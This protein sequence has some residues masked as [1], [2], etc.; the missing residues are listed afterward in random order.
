MS[1]LSFPTSP[2]TGTRYLNPNGYNTYVFDGYSW[3]ATGVDI[4]PNPNNNLFLYRTIYTRG[5]THCGYQ[6]SSPWRNTNRTMHNTDTTTNLGDMMDNS[7]AYIDVG[8]SDYYSYVWP[9]AGFQ[10][11]S[12]YCSSM[13]MQTEAV[14]SHTDNWNM[15]NNRMQSKTLMNAGNTAVYICCGSSASTDKFCT[16]TDTMF[17]AGTVGYNG[18]T[19]GGSAGSGAGFFGQYYG[20][21]ANSSSSASLAWSTDTWTTGTWTYLNGLDGINHGLSSKWG[22]GYNA[23]GSN[24][25]SVNYYKFNDTTLSYIS[26]INRGDNG[27]EENYQIGQDW[28]YELGN[29]NGV[30]NNNSFKQYYT[31]DTL[32]TGGST[33]QP[34]GHGGMS[35]GGCATGSAVLLGGTM[36]TNI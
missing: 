30:Q 16:I 4:N 29:Y 21:I 11:V 6:N 14:R 31:S 15:K 33:M 9:N 28:G 18:V 17:A 35:S 12:S 8:F 1:V 25:A 5:Y 24:T 36:G 27:G 34:K 20:T 23:G 32:V 10:G 3:M 13:N 26:T 2:S 19:S 7:A 22:L